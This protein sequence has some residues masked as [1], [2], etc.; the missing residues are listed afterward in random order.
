MG[1]F[2]SLVHL[3]F[4]FVCELR[5]SIDVFGLIMEYDYLHLYFNYRT[6]LTCLAHLCAT[7][8]GHGRIDD[9]GFEFLQIHG[10]LVYPF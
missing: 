2:L 9:P 10:S 7:S 8:F 3:M 5:H 6:F 4:C 1:Q